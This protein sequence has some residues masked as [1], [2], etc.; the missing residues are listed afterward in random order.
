[1]RLTREQQNALV[2]ALGQGGRVLAAKST[3]ASLRK[4]G[5]VRHCGE[6]GGGFVLT[7]LDGRSKAIAIRDRRAA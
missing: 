4:R 3:I 1:M 7:T 6:V 5:L 2:R